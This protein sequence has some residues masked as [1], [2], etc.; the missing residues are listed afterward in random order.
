MGALIQK[1]KKSFNYDF[2][3]KK[4][5]LA[6]LGLIIGI[7]L[8][9]FFIFLADYGNTDNDIVRKYQFRKID[10]IDFDP[11]V[12]ILGDSSAG[13]AIDAKLFSELAGQKT[14]NLAL[15]GSF[16]LVGSLQMMEKVLEKQPRIKNFV[17]MQTLDIWRR[18]FS[19]EGFFE[20]SRGFRSDYVGNKFFDYGKFIDYLQYSTSLTNFKDILRPVKK[21]L[22]N[23]GLVPWLG[24]KRPSDTIDREHDYILQEKETYSNGKK[25]IKSDNKLSDLIEPAN[26]EIYYAIDKFCGDHALRCIYLHGPMH[27][28]VVKNS[29]KEIADINN[30]IGFYSRIIPIKDVLS[31][32][33]DQVGDSINHVSVEYKK[34]TTKLYYET[35]REY[36]LE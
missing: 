11:K 5:V 35:V 27:E 21:E 25:Q 2:Q 23:S 26:R 1:I 22:I 30:I 19:R 18:P 12:V 4:F 15:T 31:L 34:N 3:P 24:Q 8:A 32:K 16:G 14:V 9:A 6:V 29:A 28:T 20:I 33:N 36:L 10:A 17:F 7:F 13:N